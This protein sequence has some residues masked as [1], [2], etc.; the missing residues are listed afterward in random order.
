MTKFLN[1]G[2]HL[3]DDDDI[4]AVVETLKSDFLTQGPKPGEFEKVFAEYV[5]AKY[6]VSVS[7]GTAALHLAVKAL[8][9]PKGKK[10]LTSPVT[11]AASANCFL[12]NGLEPGFVDIDEKTFC[13]DPTELEKKIT[14]DTAVIIP[15]HFAGQACDMEKISKIRKSGLP[16]II[17]DASHAIGSKYDNGE[18]V[19][20]CCY[21]DMCIFSF[22]PVKTIATGEGGMITTNNEKLFE[23]LM[24]LRTHGITK[25]ASKFKNLDRDSTGP[26]YYEMQELGF[27]YRLTD[28][29]ASLGISQMKKIESFAK[30]RCEIVAEYNKAFKNIEWLTPPFERKEENSLTVNHL[31]VIKIDFNLI[32][33]TRTQVMEELKTKGIGSQVHYVPVHLHPFYK[34]NFGFKQGDFP[35]AELYYQHCLSIPL[36]PAMTNEDVEY[37]INAVLSVSDGQKPF[38]EKVSGLP[39]ASINKNYKKF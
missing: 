22:H 26:W 23:K 9:I 24:M 38:R 19:G 4:N 30:R 37:V 33:K 28:I 31:Y 5:G 34:E 6:A 13:M 18:R 25:D 8:G 14:N 10:G 1:Y 7:S 29:Q 32:K 11:F 36:F 21:S 35:K 12:Y 16:F 27:N 17:E 20:S 15:V 3:I 2:K 39:K